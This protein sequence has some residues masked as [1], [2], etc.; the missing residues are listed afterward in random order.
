MIVTPGMVEMGDRQW[1]E[2]KT[3][4]THIARHDIDWAVL[5][6]NEQTAAIQEGLA[7]AEYPA[8]RVMVVNSLFEARD[9]LSPRLQSGDVVLYENDLPD[10]YEG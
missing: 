7:E 9:W 2:N 1:A 5:V 8:D 6:G 4:G 3:L 10:Q